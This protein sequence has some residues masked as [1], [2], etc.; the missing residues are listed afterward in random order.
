MSAR[1]CAPQ[2]QRQ[3]CQPDTHG[4]VGLGSQK[5]TWLWVAAA[6]SPDWSF[7]GSSLSARA[8]CG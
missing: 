3:T 6:T 7:A 5:P 8:G 4:T 1:L 2:G